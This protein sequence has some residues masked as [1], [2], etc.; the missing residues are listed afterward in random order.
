MKV[1]C[2]SQS[3]SADQARVVGANPKFHPKYQITV[4]QAYLVLG[5]SFLVRS[6]IYGTGVVFELRDDAGR[7]AS[8]P[9][10]LCKIVDPRMSKH[11]VAR[12]VENQDLLLWPE[13]FLE[14]CFHEDLSEDKP[15]AVAK[16]RRI[17]SLLEE[18]DANNV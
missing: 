14:P 7:C 3:I 16:F 15:E 10:C 13:T 11:F 17:C 8:V 4:G 18:E 1:I 12:A 6:E 9:L 2:V 5:I